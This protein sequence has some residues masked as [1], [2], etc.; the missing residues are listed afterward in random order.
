MHITRLIAG[1]VAA[2]LLGLAPVAVTAP[3]GAVATTQAAQATQQTAAP[4]RLV[5]AKPGI[6]WG[7][8]GNKIT[9]KAQGKGTVKFFLGGDL[10]KKAK[11]KRGKATY[12]MPS[13]LAPGT[14]KVKATFKK[15][16]AAIRTVVWDS[17]LNVNAATFTISASTPTY[18][19]PYPSLTGT[20]KF[21]GKI[22]S[23]GFVDIYLNGNV[24]GGNN[25]PDYC[26]MSTVLD[27]GSFS[28]GYDFLGDAQERG[29]G[30]W[31]YR[32]FYT[33]DAAF[34]DYIYSQPIT[35]TVTP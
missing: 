21:K 10:V 16:K 27:D 8:A 15:Q 33:D 23:E 2:G 4:L 24:R 25:S 13:D 3:A 31:T 34:A 35:V 19:L 18:D 20:V 29:V 28:F 7:L 32:A 14:Y 1:A 9:A 5:K 11:L 17:A 22:A 6:H 26:C 12:K 30:T